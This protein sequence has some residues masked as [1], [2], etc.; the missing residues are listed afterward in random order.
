MRRETSIIDYYVGLDLGQVQDFTALAIV[1]KRLGNKEF[2]A[3]GHYI[4]VWLPNEEMTYS[5]VYL[6]RFEL[7]TPYPRIVE[8]VASRVRALPRYTRGTVDGDPSTVFLAVDATGVGRP[9][10][11][12]LRQDQ[13]DVDLWPITIHGGNTVTQEDGYYHVPKRDLIAAVQVLMQQ[14]RLKVAQAL[15]DAQ[16]LLQELRDYRYKLTPSAHDTYNAREGQ[17]D[18]LVLA[19]GA[20][21]WA[22]ERNANHGMSEES[23]QALSFALDNPHL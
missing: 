23:M 17:H 7:R 21:V 8:N 14:K 19:L 4:N 6:E 13:L 3:S 20:A 2:D 18:D 11:D 15:P 1:E 22:G 16:V 5:V 9:V 10:V 12:L